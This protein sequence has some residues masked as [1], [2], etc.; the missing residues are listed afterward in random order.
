MKENDE[1]YGVIEISNNS[2]DLNL[3]GNVGTS[4]K[5]VR[6]TI[7]GATLGTTKDGQLIPQQN[8]GD[9]KIEVAMSK[10]DFLQLISSVFLNG[11][12]TVPCTIQKLGV[13][14]YEP[15]EPLT[16]DDIKETAMKVY[17]SEF[18]A[19]FERELEYL[20][21]YIATHKLPKEFVNNLKTAMSMRQHEINNMLEYYKDQFREYLETINTARKVE[22]DDE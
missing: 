22:G 16:E 10:L 12:H 6:L 5:H 19:K 8:Y 14:R 7:R 2:G 4:R 13:M 9:I 3:F 18:R 21:D 17:Q 1:R 20:Q 15:L 11:N